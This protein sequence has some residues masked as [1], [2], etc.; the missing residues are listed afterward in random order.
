VIWRSAIVAAYAALAIVV[1][2]SAGGRGLAILFF[3]YFWAGGWVA[4]LAVGGWAV[5]AAGRWN[6]RRLDTAVADDDEP[7][8][9]G[10]GEPEEV[11]AER[12]FE[13]TPM[14]TPKRRP[15]PAL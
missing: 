15:A 1:G 5:R 14:P 11:G 6:F 4:F 12:G 10:Y 2:I 8:G 7:D 13:P 3:F 9:P